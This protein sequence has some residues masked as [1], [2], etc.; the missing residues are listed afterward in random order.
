[1]LID[2]GPYPHSRRIRAKIFGPPYRGN[3]WSYG[4]EIWYMD[5]VREALIY[6][7][8]ITP[9]G[10]WPGS[11]GG[12]GI[13]GPLPISRMRMGEAMNFKFGVWLH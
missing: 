10:T 8:Q 3:G 4:L 13:F 6:G 11:G 7:R 9:R 5:G 12:F 1:M 2:K